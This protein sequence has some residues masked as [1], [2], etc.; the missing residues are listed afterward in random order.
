MKYF[1]GDIKASRSFDRVLDA[2]EICN[3]MNLLMAEVAIQ[4]L[5]QKARRRLKWIRVLDKIVG[6]KG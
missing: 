6:V 4:N 5:A 2:S 3:E 1:K